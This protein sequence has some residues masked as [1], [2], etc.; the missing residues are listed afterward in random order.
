MTFSQRI[1]ERVNGIAFGRLDTAA[2]Y[3]AKI[4]ILDTIGVALAG[5]A[6]P[7][8]TMMAELTTQNA[9]LGN[10]PIWGGGRCVG[11]LEAAQL[12]AMAA[13]ALD[14]DCSS[15][16]LGGHPAMCVASVFALA[17]HAG[18]DG[19]R[20]IAAVAAGFEAQAIV[21]LVA[22]P[23]H[24]ERGWF[25]TTSLG[26]LGAAA[27]SAHLLEL[28]CDKTAVALGVAANL[29]S[30]LMA[31]G[32]SMAKSLSAGHCARSGVLAAMLARKGFTASLEVF[33]HRQ[34]FLNAFG[35]SLEGP[36]G[37]PFSGPLEIARHGTAIKLYPCCG[38]IHAAI[39]IS[40]RFA[41]EG[42]DT[43]SIEKVEVLLHKRRMPQVNR[44][45]PKSDM[46]AMFS[47]QYCVAVA[48]RR[49]N[50]DLSDFE[51][52][53]YLERAIQD[54]MAKIELSAHPEMNSPKL[55]EDIG[56]E[57]VLYFRDGESR[58]A[59]LDEY[60]GRGPHNPLPDDTLDA[61]F[62]ACASRAVSSDI[63]AELLYAIRNLE[64]AQDTLG[65]DTLLGSRRFA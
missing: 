30:G 9:P 42:L 52:H 33:E 18:A 6:E 2:I 49:G 23:A 28:D 61:K 25:T 14:F 37:A 44:P 1:A 31:N 12:N 21:A 59:R 4:A 32:G 7:A 40:R 8:I 51:G 65:I 60:S 56:A 24:W 62:T 46:D 5:A 34:G 38:I 58:A 15:S 17:P 10:S 26:I 36:D 48:L 29:A 63:A 39:E 27:A 64:R 57:V 45:R 35:K 55:G 43:S 19:G 54:L 50:V 47:T 22:N 53:R 3:W 20:V 11:M 41:L 13:H 16:A